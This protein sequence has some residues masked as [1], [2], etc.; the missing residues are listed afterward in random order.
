MIITD[1]SNEGTVLVNG[2]QSDRNV[3]VNIFCDG[4]SRVTE[5]VSGNILSGT[6]LWSSGDFAAVNGSE[7]DGLAMNGTFRIQND[8]SNQM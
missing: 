5:T 1:H 8:V 4:L 2:M 3:T 7:S 6:V